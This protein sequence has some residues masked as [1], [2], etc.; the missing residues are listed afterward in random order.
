MFRTFIYVTQHDKT[1][2]NTM[3]SDE[4]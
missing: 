2:Y 4:V 3:F 1:F